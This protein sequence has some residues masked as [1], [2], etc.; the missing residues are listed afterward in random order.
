MAWDYM[1]LSCCPVEVDWPE[2]CSKGQ[3]VLERYLL[4]T[5]KRFPIPKDLEGYVRF[6]VQTFPHDFGDYS[7][8]VCRFRDE[9]EEALMFALWCEHNLPETWD[10]EPLTI[11]DWN[12]FLADHK[13][14]ADA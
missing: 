9:H 12:K 1:T 13:E 3:K 2:D 8:V 11:E 14:I 4:M 6:K 5:M 7:E 10:E